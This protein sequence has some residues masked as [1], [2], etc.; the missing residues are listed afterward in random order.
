MPNYTT[1]T[2]NGLEM[3]TFHRRP[4]T[5]TTRHRWENN[6][7][8]NCGIYRWKDIEKGII[9]TYYTDRYGKNIGRRVPECQTL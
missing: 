9:K 4:T 1:F 7:C 3:R 6:C 8:L 5:N 2:G